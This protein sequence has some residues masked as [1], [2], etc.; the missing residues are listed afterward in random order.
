[1]KTVKTGSRKGLLV[2]IRLTSKNKQPLNSYYAY[3]LLKEAL[4]DHPLIE[5]EACEIRVEEEE[6][7]SI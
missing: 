1:M 6:K 7:T 4:K 5:I 3:D 2:Q